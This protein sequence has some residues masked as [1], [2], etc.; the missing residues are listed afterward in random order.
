MPKSPEYLSLGIFGDRGVGKTRLLCTAPGAVGIVPLNGK[1]RPTIERAAAELCPDKKIYFPAQDLIRHARPMEL[2]MLNPD[3]ENRKLVIGIPAPMCCARH[4]YRWHVNRVKDA[5]WTLAE[6]PDIRTLCIDDGTQLYEDILY[7]HY[8]R[9]NRIS[10]KK[11]AYGPVNT[12]MIEIINSVKNQKHLIIVNQAK[13]EY[14][15]EVG[16]GRDTVSGFKSLGFHMSVMA[17]MERDPKS[18]T[19]YLSVRSC[20]EKASL[21]GDGGS[22]LLKNDDITFLDLAMKIFGDEIDI[23]EYM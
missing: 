3:C 7:A 12:E 9:A 22:K 1:C 20:Q 10:D 11:T 17:E 15:G 8:G 23:T 13:E 21:Y 18:G 2:A 14:R 19:F 5:L 4:Y 6:K 16:T